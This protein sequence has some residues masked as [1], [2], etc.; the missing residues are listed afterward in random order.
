MEKLAKFYHH[1]GLHP[2]MLPPGSYCWQNI[3][4]AHLQYA[5][6]PNNFDILSILRTFTKS[7]ACGP[8]GLSSQFCAL[9]D[10]SSLPNRAQLLSVASPHAASW[11]FV[12]PSPG[13][14]LHLESAE[15]QTA[16]K[17]WLGIDQFSG[18]KCPCCHTLSLD[19]LGHDALTCRYNGDAVS[20]HNRLQD[21]FFVL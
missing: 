18:E 1:Q 5:I 9:F 14:N 12:V 2:I 11:L 7:T 21:A 13:L 15:F 20:R 3:L 17:W 19:P 8:S 10:S 16:M 4:K 6:L